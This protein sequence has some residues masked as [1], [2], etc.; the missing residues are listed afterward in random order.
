MNTLLLWAPL[1]FLVVAALFDLKKREVPDWVSLA[2]LAWGAFTLVMGWHPSNWLGLIV[3]A[4]IPF[5]LSLLFFWLGGLGGADVKL[6]T[7]L[8]AV[9]GPWAI[10]PTLF[11]VALAGG[12]LSLKA[13]FGGRRNLAYVPAI[14]VGLLVSIITRGGLRGVL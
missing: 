11:W 5:V 1:P 6:L 13:C 10:L 7:A 9:L 8:G 4:A 12:V 2:L 3:G 14:L